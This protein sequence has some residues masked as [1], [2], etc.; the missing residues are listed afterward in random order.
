[1]DTVNIPETNRGCVP[2]FQEGQQITD[3]RAIRL[4][5]NHEGICVPLK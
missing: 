4:E 3:D 2:Q 1:M 5:L